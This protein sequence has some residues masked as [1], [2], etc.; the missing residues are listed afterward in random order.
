MQ[1]LNALITGAF[2]AGGQLGG[3]AIEG[4]FAKQQADI[5][6]QGANSQAYIYGAAQ[7]N[8]AQWGS[9]GGGY[10]ASQVLAAQL[11]QKYQS[12]AAIAKAKT[13]AEAKKMQTIL[14]VVLAA[15]AL[16]IGAFVLLNRK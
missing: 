10:G 7:G 11:G 15:S 5:A 4:S 16:L 14:I 3:K 13:E 1:W 6:A 12:Q 2:Q 9:V 8:V